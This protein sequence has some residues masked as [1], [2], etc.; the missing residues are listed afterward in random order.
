LASLALKK[1]TRFAVI[2]EGLNAGTSAMIT[3]KFKTAK[4]ALVAAAFASSSFALTIDFGT[5]W[6]AGF[7]APNTGAYA[8]SP[9]DRLL[10]N[11]NEKDGP[12]T[13]IATFINSGA[14]TSFAAADIHKTNGASELGGSDGYF[15]VPSGWKYLFVQYGGSSGDAMLLELDG[16]D[17]KVPFDSSNIYGTGDKYAVSHFALAGSLPAENA[18]PDGGATAGLMGIGLIGLAVMRKFISK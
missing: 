11:A 14:A 16:Y 2:K 1:V 4:M 12:E 7:T 9:Y 6:P 17:A 13:D 5:T 18:V 3:T 15:T 10:K 8:S